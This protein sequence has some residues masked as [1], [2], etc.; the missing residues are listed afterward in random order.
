MFASNFK[1]AM[2]I[3]IHLK[4]LNRC[5]PR[6]DPPFLTTEDPFSQANKFNKFY[7]SVG[8]SAALKA[9]PLAEEHGFDSLGHKSTPCPLN[10]CLHAEQC[11]LFE[12]QPVTEEEVGKIIRSL[13]STKT[14]GLDKVTA[15]VLKDSLP[16]TL[17][18]ITNLVNTSFSSST[19]AQV[20]KSAE[21]IPILK[22]GDSDEPSNTRPISLLPIMSKVC[23]RSAHSQV[24]KFLDQNGKNSRLQSGNR[25]FHSTETTLLY[26]AD[27][28]LKNMD[29]KK[30]SMIV[31]LDMSKAFDSIRH[32]PML[33]KL[34]NI[35]MSSGACSWFRSYLSQR[36][37]VVNIANSVSD[38]LPVTVGV[39]QGSILGPVL[40]TL[41]ANDL[42]SVPRHCQVMGYVDDTKIFLGFPS[43]QISDAVT[44]LNKDLSEIAR[45]CCT[46]SLLI[47]PDKTKLLVI[48]VPQLTRSLPSIPPVKLLGKEIKPVTVAKDLGVIIDSSLSFNEHVTKT[49]IVCIG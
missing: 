19:F 6:K 30:V 16:M 38:P 5:L 4:V 3:Q 45:W 33:S 42:L 46:N 35:G 27:E 8:I 22:S 24:V 44:A 40:S 36:C 37:Q 18:A 11:P 9:K 47:N 12:F 39:P 13:P 41:Y 26:F 25:R 20:W 7:T 1:T 28:I 23:E 15:R 49:V 10:S 34:H 31:L 17:S 21:V 14:P 2:G 48:G 29:D 32:D 43:S